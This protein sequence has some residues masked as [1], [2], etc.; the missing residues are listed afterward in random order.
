MSALEGTLLP[1]RHDLPPKEVP[2]QDKLYTK[3]RL[4]FIRQLMRHSKQSIATQVFDQSLDFLWNRWIE[5][6]KLIT[7]N[8]LKRGTSMSIST[9]P[10]YG[11]APHQGANTSQSKEDLFLLAVD[12]AKPWLTTKTYR[13]GGK[14]VIIPE[15]INPSQQESFAIRWLVRNSRQ[16]NRSGPQ[17]MASCLGGELFGCL[18]NQG[19]TINQ[20]EQVH[21]LAE[22]NRAWVQ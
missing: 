3:I 22:I 12:K 19:R 9:V 1:D 7:T 6:T 10:T 4:K 8:Q 16:L 11:M 20:R 2:H 18:T 15:M 5:H 13:R 21:K 17:P 14:S